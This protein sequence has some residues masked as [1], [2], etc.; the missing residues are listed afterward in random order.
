MELLTGVPLPSSTSAITFDT[1]VMFMGSCFAGEIGYRMVSGKLPVMV[2][3]HG[4]LFN[5]FSVA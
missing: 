1:P 3:P 2:N 5:P 4:T